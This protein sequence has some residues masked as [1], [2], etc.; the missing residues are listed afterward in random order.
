LDNVKGSF[1]DVKACRPTW[2]SV[3]H[4]EVR[5]NDS[6]EDTASG[7]SD[8]FAEKRFHPFSVE[9]DPPGTGLAKRLSSI[10]GSIRFA[11][12]APDILET[13]NSSLQLVAVNFFHHGKVRNPTRAAAGKIQVGRLSVPARTCLKISRKVIDAACRMPASF[14][15]RFVHDKDI[16]TC[17]SRG[18]CGIE[19]CDAA[20]DNKDVGLQMFWIHSGKRSCAS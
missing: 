8:C 20:A 1:P 6:V 11:E 2:D 3:M 7:F 18:Q 10:I 14:N 12:S 16:Q 19:A 9:V 5:C 15:D 13:L 4:Q 17:F